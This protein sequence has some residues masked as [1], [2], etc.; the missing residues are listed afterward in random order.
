MRSKPLGITLLV[1]IA[2]T[3]GAAIWLLNGIIFDA[4]RINYYEEG[5][6]DARSEVATGQL[7]LKDAAADSISDQK[8]KEILERFHGV[9]HDKLT[10]Q[11]GQKQLAEYNRGYNDVMEPAIEKHLGPLVLDQARKD[12]ADQVHQATET[13]EYEVYSAVLDEIERDQPVVLVIRDETWDRL[14]REDPETRSRFTLENMLDL[15]P[16]FPL[17]ESRREAIE[18]YKTK[19][20]KPMELKARFA[21][22][23]ECRLMSKRAFSAFFSGADKFGSLEDSWK[24]Y[25]KKYPHSPGY[26]SLSG[27]GFNKSMTEALVYVELEC[28]SLCA[29]GR[30]KFV[31]KERC[32]W[33][34]KDSFQFYVS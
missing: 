26:I 23:S 19:N 8:Y 27:V 29:F 10:P 17:S 33:E 3:C 31:A 21:V 1:V 32:R 11:P 34:I 28:G 5:Q 13:A 4:D 24:N 12:A 15:P 9:A 30:F 2:L 22:R 14:S 7:R 18:D 20:E 16:L 25:Y 6:K